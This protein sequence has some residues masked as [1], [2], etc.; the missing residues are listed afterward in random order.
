MKPTVTSVEGEEATSAGVKPGDVIIAMGE[1][2][3]YGLHNNR[4]VVDQIRSRKVGGPD[5]LT[6]PITFYREGI[7]ARAPAVPKHARQEYSERG[8][9][10]RSKSPFVYDS[11]F[12]Y[13]PKI[14]AKLKARLQHRDKVA[15]RKKARAAAV[16]A[17]QA[18]RKAARAAQKA[19]LAAAREVA[20][21]QKEQVGF[22]RGR[23]S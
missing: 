3:N 2:G 5:N 11:A 22:G 15:A 1:V 18:A 6:F 14:V 16:A 19:A 12:L 4:F 13:G 8:T 17:R 20:R 23:S 10:G 9:V 21:A 7:R